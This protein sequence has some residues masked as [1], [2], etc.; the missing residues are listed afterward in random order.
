[1]NYLHYHL[2][3]TLFFFKYW[4]FLELKNDYYFYVK[5]IF[6][7]KVM[8]SG[9]VRRPIPLWHVD[10]T[11]T[12]LR[13]MSAVSVHHLTRARFCA[14]VAIHMSFNF[15]LIMC[16]ILWKSYSHSHHYKG[17]LDSPSKYDSPFAH[18][19]HTLSQFQ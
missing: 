2:G 5:M 17:D 6:L 14:S 3:F 4:I 16:R 15:L 8:C 18:V 11:S 7:K 12:R 1:M 19:L 9:L 13:K 10:Q